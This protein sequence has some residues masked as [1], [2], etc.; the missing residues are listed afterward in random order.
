[1]ADSRSP[2]R[3][4]IVAG[5][6]VA[7]TLNGYA[8]RAD[9]TEACLASY[10]K[11]QRLRKDG[12]FG[13]SR[14]E[15]VQCVRPTCPGIVKR[16]C[17]Q[18]MAELDVATPTVIVNARDADGKDFVA[19]KVLV[20]GVLL[21]EK[22]DGKPHEVDPGV[23]VFRFESQGSDATEQ[24]VVVQEREKNRVITVR[25]GNPAPSAAPPEPRATSGPPLASYVLF[26]AG[27]AGLATFGILAAV[28]KSELDDM[29]SQC[30]PSCDPS[31]VDEARTKIIVADVA[32][33]VGIVAAGL[34]TYFLLA[35]RKSAPS[36]TFGFHPITGGG[37]GDFAYRF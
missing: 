16:D 22:L 8:A 5:S 3:A 6:L 4:R 14:D 15:L 28:G 7:L 26:G 10:E 2:I 24:N 33:G 9:D 12:K 31:R 29:R 37:A 1:M 27:A 36:V 13:A 11:S 18:W 23:H 32:A 30:A 25:L 19:V 20:D 17:S 34:G 35:P 21:V